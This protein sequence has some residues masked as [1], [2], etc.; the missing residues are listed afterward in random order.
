MPT[1]KVNCFVR[2]MTEHDV[3]RS[4]EEWRSLHIVRVIKGDPLK[5]YFSFPINGYNKSINENNKNEF[6]SEI[7]S[8]T[9]KQIIE[10]CGNDV[11]IVPIPNSSAVIGDGAI[12]QTLRLARG[13]CHAIGAD[14]QAVPLLRW[15]SQQEKAHE[16]GRK[17][18]WATHY[19]NLEIAAK[20]NKKIVLFDDVLT[21]GSQMYAGK[22][23]LTDQGYDVHSM[24]AIA[25]ILEHGKRSD[26]FGW[27]VT[28]RHIMSQGDLF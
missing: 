10:S 18:D 13:V 11:A 20:T 22:K 8:L 21:T 1:I 12:F 17:R 6:L 25:S 27:K 4:D 2:H 5:G 24:C 14:A 3:E 15:K 23:I 16:G 19:K 28:F 26:E 7:Y 9:A